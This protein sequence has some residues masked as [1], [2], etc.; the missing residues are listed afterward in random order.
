MA[1]LFNEIDDDIRHQKLVTF[2]K[3]NGAAIIGGAVLAVVFTGVLAFWRYYDG[4]QN[5][6]NTAVL[7]KSLR[8]GDVAQITQTAADLRKPHAAMA[9]F[10][11]AA[12]ALQKGQKDEAVKIYRDIRETSRLDS[13][14]RD[15]ASVFEASQTLETAAPK[16][17]HDMLKSATG[18][19]STWRFSALELD[20]LV[21]AREGKNSDAA[22][23]LQK[24]LSDKDAPSD[25]RARAETL[26][27]MYA[28]N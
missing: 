25:I 28:A 27:D 7:L 12:I 19:K 26:R 20:A 18:K 21:Y 8:T 1:D 2:W 4:G 14:W 13:T 16:D 23:S 3:E 9:K 24:I 15:L 22:A 11:A 10:T 5:R 17:L 6:D